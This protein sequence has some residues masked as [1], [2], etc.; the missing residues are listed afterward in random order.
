VAHYFFSTLFS[1]NY[2]NAFE[3]VKVI[4][5]NIGTEQNKELTNKKTQKTLKSHK[6]P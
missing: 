5:Q 2:T 6:K 1:K 3:F 4:T